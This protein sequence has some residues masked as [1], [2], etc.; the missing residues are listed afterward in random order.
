[1][2]WREVLQRLKAAMLL[3]G[4]G[5]LLLFIGTYKLG[6]MMTDVLYKPFLVDAGITAGQIGLWLGTW[7]ITTSLL[8]SLL[9]GVLATRMPLLGALTLTA[10]LRILPLVGRWW[11]ASAGVTEAGFVGVTLAEEF[12]GGALTTVMFAFM[13]SRVDRRIGATHYTLLAS[14][15]VLG[16]FPGGPIGGVLAQD[17]GWSYA[18][19]FLLGIVLSVAFL[20][21][22][23]PLRK[24]K[25]GTPSPHPG[26]LPEGEGVSV[27]QELQ[28]QASD[29]EN[30]R[31]SGA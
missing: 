16:K 25:Q 11:L 31:K 30:R 7:G 14:V 23:V 21:L 18:R 29:D 19:V 12:F 13:M 27:P 2:H 4:A 20:G 9:G 6:E 1:V 17:Y 10:S 22:L 28:R 8:G 3:P 5:W 24:S 15:E 26:P